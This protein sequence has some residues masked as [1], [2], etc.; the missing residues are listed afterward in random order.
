MTKKSIK[1]ID[2]VKGQALLITIMLVSVALTVVLTMSYT[3]KTDLQ[4]SKLEEENQQALAA[5]EAGI[6]ALVNATSSTTT[7]ISIN[8]LKNLDDFK[9]EAIKK[10]LT[11]NSFVSPSIQKLSQYTLY[12]SQYIFNPESYPVFYNPYSGTMKVYYGQETDSCTSN[13]I[14]ISIIYGDSPYS[15]KRFISANNEL[16]GS[17]TDNIFYHEG[18]YTVGEEKFRCESNDINFADYPNSKL[19]VVRPIFNTSK[20]GF[21]GSE[22]LPSQGTVIESSAE[23]PSGV[24]KK[25]QLFQS[26]PQIPAEFFV[27]S[28]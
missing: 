22:N 26:F 11:G 18:V 7:E 25:I 1:I 6:E 23:T 10:T 5:A 24:S 2:K 21:K 3:T 14:E 15:I 13:A 19:M 4:L 27:T 8:T 16:L 20:V 17:Q 28:F 9:G 12:L